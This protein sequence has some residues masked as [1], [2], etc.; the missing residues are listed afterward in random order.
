MNQQKEKTLF[1]KRSY[2]VGD[3]IWFLVKIAF[4]LISI[5]V[6][7]GVT[8]GILTTEYPD[9]PLLVRL[10][11]SAIPGPLLILKLSVKKFF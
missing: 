8:Y 7:I 4:L 1:I 9:S 3:N 10:V 5:I 11:M 2:M 6:V